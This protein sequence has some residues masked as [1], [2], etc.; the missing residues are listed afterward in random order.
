MA[1]LVAGA[2]SSLGQQW[3]QVNWT[4]IRAQVYRL[5]MRI[6]KAVREKRWNKVKA[7]QYLLSRS[8]NAKLLAVKLVVSNKGSRTPGIDGIKWKTPRQRWLAALALKKSRLPCT[9]AIT[10]NDTQ[11]EWSKTTIGYPY[12]TR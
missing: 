1:A 4:E 7:L 2:P 6:A 12:V 5:Q 10:H 3:K 8:F 11:K 9:T